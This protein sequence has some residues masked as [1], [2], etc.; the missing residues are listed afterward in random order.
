[1]TTEVL[2]SYLFSEIPKVNGA[3]VLLNEGGVPSILSGITSALPTATVPG[4]LFLDTTLNKFF[5]DTGSAWIDLTPVPSIDGTA[6]QIAVTPGTNIT[7]TVIALSA[8]PTIPGTGG[9]LI[10][11]GTT[12]ERP[13]TPVTGTV[14]YN[15]T[16]GYHEKFTGAYW[17]PYGRLLQVSTVNITAQSGT[18]TVP[19]D[20]TT[21][22]NTE[23][24]Q[25][26]ST[27]FTPL[28]ATS[29]ILI[30]LS[31]TCSMSGTGSMIG[32]IFAGTTNIGAK[33]QIRS[34]TSGHQMSWNISYQPGSTATITFSGRLGGSANS[35][36]YVN[37]AGTVTLGGAL[38]SQL[39]IQE[40]E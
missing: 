25:F 38:A 10:P 22:T 20:N 29:R 31:I 30:H 1:M 16:L 21:P 34:S 9:V 27:T 23:G 15:S 6:G 32:S 17:G 24:W 40:V 11:T 3:D 19:L 28:S 7:P 12:A 5:R 4:R 26:F 2:G 37:S 18:T 35:T 13:D 39:I 36:S 14:R 33:A 8:N